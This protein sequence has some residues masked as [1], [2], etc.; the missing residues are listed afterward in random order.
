MLL[1]L[2]IIS[3]AFTHASSPID[4]Y[5]ATI[6]FNAFSKY[7]LSILTGKMTNLEKASFLNQNFFSSKSFV[8][9][10][11][12]PSHD[13]FDATIFRIDCVSSSPKCPF[14]S[15]RDH[16]NRRPKEIIIIAND[17]IEVKAR[18]KCGLYL[19]DERMGKEKM[20][21]SYVRTVDTARQSHSSK[22]Q[23]NRG[24]DDISVAHFPRFR[25]V[26]VLLSFRLKIVFTCQQKRS[27]MFW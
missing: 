8:H 23:Q 14:H 5:H 16:Y 7:C 9:T 15:N 26:S 22:Q 10:D 27:E 1:L 4:V 11:A 6:S 20:S 25:F 2:E 17:Y 24:S 12:T 21:D 19:S 18:L 13:A 3:N